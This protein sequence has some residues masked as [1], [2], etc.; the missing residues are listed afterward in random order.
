MSLFDEPAT[1]PTGP[2]APSGPSVRVRLQVAYD[3]RRFHG[4]AAQA[5]GVRT[6]AG[7]L[8]SALQRV[9]RLP[10]APVLTCAGRTDAGVHARGQW[11][12]FDLPAPASPAAAEPA[13][14][15][16]APASAEHAGGTGAPTVAAEL[17][18]D[19]GLDLAELVRRLVKMLGP[20]VVVRH[21]GISPPGWDA[22]HSAISRTYRYTVLTT[23]VPDPFTAGFVWWLGQPLDLRS[24]QLACDA[25]VGERDFSSFCRKQLRAD[26]HI[27]SPVRRVSDAG[28]SEPDEGLARFE[29]TA[30]A[31]CHQM[32]RSLVG[33]LVDVGT[34]RRR[35]GEM[36]GIIRARDR[37]AAGSVAP[38]DG[39]GLWS[40][41]YPP[42]T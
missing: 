15:E 1:T 23:P 14:V 41:G 19:L 7:V 27:A 26:G 2:T 38:P 16:P 31:F 13:A 11:V 6:V 35:A 34:G 33:T 20:E 9:L 8:A 32:V 40:V 25:L 18:P 5:A 39:L 3:G 17:V 36:L 37:A 12:H 24:M 4:F 22:R 30:N 21:A 10:E 28:W 29:I 42:E